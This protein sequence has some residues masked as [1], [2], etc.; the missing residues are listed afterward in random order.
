MLCAWLQPGGPVVRKWDIFRR[1]GEAVVSLGYTMG[2][3]RAVS[4]DHLW[5]PV[6][7]GSG[8]GRRNTSLWLSTA[9]RHARLGPII[10]RISDDVACNSWRVARKSAGKLVTAENTVLNQWMQ[11]PWD[12]L[13][14][15]GT[16]FD[17]QYLTCAWLQ[18]VG[19][20]FWV[21]RWDG[22]RVQTIPFPPSWVTMTPMDGQDYYL[23]CVPNNMGQTAER[24]PSSN[25]IWLR[26][27][28]WSNPYGRG[29]GRAQF[30]DDEVTQDE[31]AAKWE[32]AYW[33][34]SA[35]P[36]LVV[37]VE[38][39]EQ[40]TSQVEKLRRQ[41]NEVHQ[42]IDRAH[43][44]AFLPAKGRLEQV[45]TTLQD[46]ALIELRNAHRDSIWQAYQ[47]PPEVMGAVE[48]SNRAT[49]DAALNIYQR[50]VLR[51]YCEWMRQALARWF[52]PK[53]GLL[54]LQLIPNDPVEE[55][56]DFRLAKATEMYKAGLLTRDEARQQLGEDPDGG[57][58]GKNYSVP[59]NTAELRPDGSYNIYKPG[60]EPSTGSAP[61]PNA[62]KNRIRA[63]ADAV[64]PMM[65]GFDV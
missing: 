1:I 13:G 45:K 11:S 6:G 16:W 52:V 40:N 41:W 3:E 36:D 25:V 33:R 19:E 2:A 29:L 54:N 28:S 32:N 59:L 18:T 15:G 24:I 49:A 51:V 22:K 5:S 63:I 9:E 46:V 60:A 23:I 26:K 17:L 21:V 64:L 35:R 47:V 50:N 7:Y 4:Q 34:N 14:I 27:P 39:L 43:A 65:E 53:F 48:N 10:S 56:N 30:I 37:F 61:D 57:S 42:G 31:A 38:G 8:A 58:N 12:S 62:K 44:P 20:A 55:S